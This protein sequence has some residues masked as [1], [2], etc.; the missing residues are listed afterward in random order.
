MIDLTKL[1]K[2][3]TDDLMQMC[4][5]FAPSF[6]YLM[7][8]V[9]DGKSGVGQGIEHAIGEAEGCQIVLKVLKDRDAFLSIGEVCTINVVKL[10]NN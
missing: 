10:N 2:E 8:L 5:S 3:E 6:I 4:E 7:G 1:T 9:A